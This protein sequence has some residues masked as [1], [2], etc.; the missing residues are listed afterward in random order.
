MINF[1]NKWVP[2]S[3]AAIL[4]VGSVGYVAYRKIQNAEAACTTSPCVF[5]ATG[6]GSWTIPAGVTSVQG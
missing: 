1:Y 6:S 5:T 3:L 2:I 4:I